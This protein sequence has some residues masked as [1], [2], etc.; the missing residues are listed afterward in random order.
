MYEY[1]LLV[2]AG[3]LAY[4][5]AP[6]LTI[7]VIASMLSL[8]RLLKIPSSQALSLEVATSMSISAL[9]ATLAYL[10]GHSVALL[11]GH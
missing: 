11:L 4:R 7:V 1:V 3:W 6:A 9:F 10:V 5:G 8:P 2:L